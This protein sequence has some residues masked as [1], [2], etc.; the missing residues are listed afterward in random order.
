LEIKNLATEMKRV[1]QCE[2]HISAQ[3]VK[4]HGEEWK[5]QE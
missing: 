2:I 3:L 5:V 4:L 1:L